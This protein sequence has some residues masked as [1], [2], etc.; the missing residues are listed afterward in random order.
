MTR[1]LITGGAGFIG[2]HLSEVLLDKGYEVTII[3]DLSTGR[4]E[5]VEH[6]TGNPHFHF[7]IETIANTAV[8]DRLVSECDIIFHLAAAVGVDLI[9]SKPIHVIE[10]NIGGSEIVLQT[11]RRYRRKVMLASTSEVYGKSNSAPFAED[12]DSV[13][14]PTIKN[15]WSYAATKAVDEFL[16]LA[17]HKEIELPVVIF[18]L[19][20]TVGVRQSG[21]YGMVIPRFVQAALKDEPIRVFGDGKQTR[22]FGNVSDSVRAIIALSECDEA[23]GQVFNVG[24]QE[25][26]TILELAERVKTRAGSGSEI[27]LVP[28]NEAYEEGFED[29]RRR[30]PDTSKIQRMVGWKAEKTLDQT[31]DEVIAYFRKRIV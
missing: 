2:G 9:V 15:R 27:M 18:R 14:G 19:F 29:M 24:T 11:A 20:N 6:L 30:I 5:N 4:F 8:M 23:V 10:T 31:L 3:D 22:C 26:V 16:A 7:A 13:L 12:D 25:E 28:Y 21:R 1:A 17:Y